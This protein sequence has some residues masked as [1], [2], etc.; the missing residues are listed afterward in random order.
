MR[1]HIT[2]KSNGK[3]IPFQHQ[4]LLAGTIY[5]WIGNTE[6][7]GKISLYSFSGIEGLDKTDEGFLVSPRAKMFFSSFDPQLIQKLIYGIQQDNSMFNGLEATQLVIME[8]PEINQ[9]TYFH[10]GSPVLIKRLHNNQITFY[11]YHEL[12]SS[13]L[14]EETLHHKMQVAGLAIDKSLKI[15]FDLLYKKATQRLI[16]YNGISNKVNW[17][18]VIIEGKVETKQFALNVGLGNSTGIGFGAIKYSIGKKSALEY[19]K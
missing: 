4:R 17:C 15:R 9:L 6:K 11:S 12:I 19:V 1:L 2:I 8:E 16:E 18:P 7:H 14:L 5:K 3:T 13:Q 10:L